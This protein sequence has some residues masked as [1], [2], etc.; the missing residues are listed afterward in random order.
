MILT[1]YLVH[2]MSHEKSSGRVEEC[3]RPD[4]KM[5]RRLRDFP[6]RLDEHKN[7][8]IRVVWATGA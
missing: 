1:L 6:D 4:P 2:Q 7:I 8:R 3:T 5:R